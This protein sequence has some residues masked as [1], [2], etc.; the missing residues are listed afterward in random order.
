MHADDVDHA[1]H[2]VQHL[3]DRVRQFRETQRIVAEDLHFNG[4]GVAFEVAEHVL[5]ELHELDVD[6]RHR[7]VHLVADLVDDFF[8]RPA[9]LVPGLEA[10]ENVAG[11]LC[12]RKQTELRSRAP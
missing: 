6:E 9:A 7:L 4:L 3:L 12:G 5:Q 11:V 1:L 10:Y 2:L 8:G